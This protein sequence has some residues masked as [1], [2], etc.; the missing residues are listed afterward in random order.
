MWGPNNEPTSDFRPSVELVQQYRETRNI[1]NSHSVRM[2]AGEMAGYFLLCWHTVRHDHTRGAID[3]EFRL[4]SSRESPSCLCRWS[5]SLGDRNSC[6]S[7]YLTLALLLNTSPVCLHSCRGKEEGL[8][9]SAHKRRPLFA[10]R[11]NR[12]FHSQAQK[13][14]SPN[15]LKINVLVR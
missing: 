4:I 2:M 1:M 3:R 12:P 8:M 11:L 9:C 6:W 10:P 5:G 14:H 7:S 15:L 13:V